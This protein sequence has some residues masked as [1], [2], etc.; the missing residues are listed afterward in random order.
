MMAAF[1]SSSAK[2]EW[3]AQAGAR[4]DHVVTGTATLMQWHEAAPPRYIHECVYR[5]KES[6][7]RR[8][9]KREDNLVEYD[10]RDRR[11]WYGE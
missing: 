6:V 2:A 1:P 7:K 10:P 8:I 5:E 4:G 3:A 9:F 11:E